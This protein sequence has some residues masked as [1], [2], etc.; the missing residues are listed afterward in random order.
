VKVNN[1]SINQSI[2]FDPAN[3]FDPK[4]KTFFANSVKRISN[5]FAVQLLSKILNSEG[6]SGF[7][8]LRKDFADTAILLRNISLNNTF[9][10][11]R[12][13]S[14][15]GLDYNYLN[16]STKQLLTYGLA[17]NENIQQLLKTR[18]AISKSLNSNLIGKLG[19]R[20]NFSGVSDGN[21]F[22]QRYWSVEPALIWIN[23]SI[24][25][26][27]TSLRH[28]ERKNEAQ[29]GGEFAQIQSA[30]IE[31]RYSQTAA[32]IVQLRFTFSQIKYNGL[33]TAP[34]AYTMLDGLKN[35]NNILWYINWQR[36]VGKGIELLIEYEGRKAADQK[37]V[38]T[39]RM[40]LRA[41]L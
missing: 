25:R 1:L 41:V 33:A 27:T 37:V 4:N 20:S 2:N 18:F 31:A 5:Q 16:N 39:G 21:S 7:D 29:Y 11:N 6:I 9:Y 8:P 28:E 38:N 3:L 19:H 12:S 23:R 10:F 26:I 15:W 30:N 24:I 35:G 13:S 17:T 14:K 34:V 22:F 36:R 40:S 32:G